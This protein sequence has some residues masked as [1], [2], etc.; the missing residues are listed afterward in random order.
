MEDQLLALGLTYILGIITQNKEVKK[1]PKDFVTSSMK[2]VRSWF[3]IDDPVITSIVENPALPEDV[4]KPVIEAK[5]NALKDNPEFMKALATQ[6]AE[7]Q[8]QRERLKNVVD[9]SEIEVVGNVHIGDKGKSS[10]D[11]FDQ[12]NVIKSSK[13]K[14]GGD[15]RLGDD[16]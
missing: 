6:L 15:F 4:K 2:F 11:D 8:V 1:F 5:L 3:L 12:K 14:V 13:I 9:G 16:A 7:Y 10:G